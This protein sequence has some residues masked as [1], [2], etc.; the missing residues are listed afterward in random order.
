MECWWDQAEWSVELWSQPCLSGQN[1]GGRYG[2]RVLHDWALKYQH[3][4]L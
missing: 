2:S 3:G 4:E 1:E